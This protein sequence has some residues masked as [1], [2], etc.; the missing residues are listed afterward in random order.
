MKNVYRHTQDGISCV[1][2]VVDDHVGEVH[3]QEADEWQLARPT[4][5]RCV[6]RTQVSGYVMYQL[7]KIGCGVAYGKIVLLP[8]SG[9]QRGC[10]VPCHHHPG[11]LGAPGLCL[12]AHHLACA[13]S[14]TSPPPPGAHLLLSG[15][16]A[17]QRPGS[18]GEQGSRLVRPPCTAA[19]GLVGC[20]M[21]ASPGI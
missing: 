2:A 14:L 15:Q 6:L 10:R 12:L 1:T 3:A 9:K 21:D 19:G 8:V 20:G 13:P 16:A 5:A 4:T 18:R 11:C 7:D 17:A